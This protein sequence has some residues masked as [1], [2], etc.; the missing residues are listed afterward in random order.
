M[1]E[2]EQIGQAVDEVR[3]L[4]RRLREEYD[5]TYAS[6]IGVLQLEI[7]RLGR[8]VFADDEAG[9]EDDDEDE[10]EGEAEVGT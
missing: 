7:H 5:L 3:A 1:D 8:E 9:T 4:M 2:R 6:L 10:D